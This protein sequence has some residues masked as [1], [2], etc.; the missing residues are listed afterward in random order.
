VHRIDL[1]AGKGNVANVVARK[2]LSYS[3]YCVAASPDGRLAV[4]CNC[5]NAALLDAP[6]AAANIHG[7]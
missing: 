5:G 6:A 3:V 4:C 7:I 2:Q 1:V